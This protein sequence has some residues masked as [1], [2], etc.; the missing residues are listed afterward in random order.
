MAHNLKVVGSNPTPAT[1]I[2]KCFSDLR[3]A[4]KG[5]FCVS[6][7]PG[8][9]VEARGREILRKLPRRVSV[10]PDPPYRSAP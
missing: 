8:S 7:T 1:K 9:T 3:G 4:R 10:R 2:P 5:A 6:S